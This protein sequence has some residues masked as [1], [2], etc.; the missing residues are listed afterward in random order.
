MP[1]TTNSTHETFPPFHIHLQLDANGPDD[2]STPCSVRIVLDDA[3]MDDIAAAAA[4][5]RILAHL[6]PQSQAA[7]I[8]STTILLNAKTTY[9]SDEEG[10]EPWGGDDGPGDGFW[11]FEASSEWLEVTPAAPGQIQ[12]RME[13]WE[14]KDRDVTLTAVFSAAEVGISDDL[15][16]RVVGCYEAMNIP[17]D[18][19]PQA[20]AHRVAAVKRNPAVLATY[21]VTQQTAAVVDA[22]LEANPLSIIAVRNVTAEH[23]LRALQADPYV[24]RVLPIDNLGSNALQPIVAWLAADDNWRRVCEQPW[25]EPAHNLGAPAR[26][27]EL[28]SKLGAVCGRDAPLPIPQRVL[29]ALEADGQPVTMVR[30]RQSM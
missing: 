25:N 12:L 8:A 13:V 7:T 5:A 9:F 14:R 4:G 17:Q 16:R 3:T 10:V 2:L 11:R 29:D 28:A 30:S 26:L 15:E 6:R 20:E 22:A 18:Y 23:W 21:D 27:Q 19:W 24:A 1:T